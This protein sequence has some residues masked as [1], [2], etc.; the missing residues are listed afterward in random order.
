MLH[1]ALV[2]PAHFGPIA[3]TKYRGLRMANNIDRAHRAL[4][5][6]DPGTNRDTWVRVAM[7]AE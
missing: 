4:H 6:I 1:T 5:A 3:P 2:I 7:D